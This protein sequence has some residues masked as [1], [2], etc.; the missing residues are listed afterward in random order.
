MK[1]NWALISGAI[2]VTLVAIIFGL[3]YQE[4]QKTVKNITPYFGEKIDS[5][6]VNELCLMKSELTDSELVESMLKKIRELE[7]GEVVAENRDNFR[8]L[9]FEE[10]NRV[11]LRSGD[12]KIELGRINNSYSG[13]YV[14]V[15][16]NGPVY[17]TNVIVDKNEVIRADYWQRKWLTN[18][19]VYQI[20]EVKIKERGKER[21]LVARDNKWPEE[22]LINALAHVRITKLLGDKQPSKVLAEIKLTTEKESISLIMGENWGTSDGK[23]YFE[24]VNSI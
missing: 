7:I 8:K 16:E 10:N 18:L 12:K 6:C 19:S 14:R 2:L 21:V 22:E 1:N 3:K 17:T 11:W 15:D 20:S 9:G 23:N 24:T 4:G 13:T 5:F